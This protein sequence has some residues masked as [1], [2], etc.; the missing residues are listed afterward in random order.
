MDTNSINICY[1]SLPLDII[2]I[3]KDIIKDNNIDRTFL[4]N[5]LKDN[6]YIIGYVDLK[7]NNIISFIWF[8]I[9]K[10]N[11]FGT[12]TH[13]NYS[14]TFVKYRQNGLNVKLRIQI[15]KFCFENKIQTLT[16]KPFE[17][18]LS[19]KIL[20]GLGFCNNSNYYY[21]KINNI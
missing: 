6:E 14:Y 9:Y 10:N 11:E 5:Q 2:K 1:V 16:S 20:L 8:G 21:K 17:D 18:S 4:P 12:F 13:I 19:K 3:N 7:T 15:E